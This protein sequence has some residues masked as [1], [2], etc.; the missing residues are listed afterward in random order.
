MNNQPPP[1]KVLFFGDS[2][3]VG[4]YVS[5]HQGWVAQMSQQLS[6]LGKKH[7][8]QVLVINAS[9]NG[10][11]TRQALEIMP[12]EVQSKK[13]QLVIVQYGMNDS[14]YWQTDQGL[15]RVSP[16]SFKANLKEIITRAFNFG[17]QRLILNTNH[18]TGRD[19]NPLPSTNTTYQKSNQEY[20]QIIRQV[21]KQLSPQVILNDIEKSFYSHLENNH[22]SI[23]DFLLPHPDLLHPNEKGHQLYFQA[24][25][26]LV[27]RV[28]LDII[29]P[30]K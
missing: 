13:P 4:Q 22:H 30:K 6:L 10:R 11:T 19:K 27:K 7:H 26:P 24:T 28:V 20:N 15:P 16:E 25:Y 1:I 14:N 18:P 2:I 9:A 8:R 23:S 21:A 5:I 3:C 12:Y 29:R 17:A